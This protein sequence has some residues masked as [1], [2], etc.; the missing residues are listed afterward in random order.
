[1]YIISS[2]NTGFF[3]HLDIL[4]DLIF[5]HFI[6]KQEVMLYCKSSQVMIYA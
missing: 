5:A 6:N 2:Q 3:L 4:T 1:M